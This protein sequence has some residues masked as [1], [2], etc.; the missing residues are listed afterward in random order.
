ADLSHPF[1]EVVTYT[2]EGPPAKQYPPG[3]IGVYSLKA[4][5]IAGTPLETIAQLYPEGPHPLRDDLAH[6]VAVSPTD[7][8]LT[9]GYPPEAS[10]VVRHVIFG[11]AR[12][13]ARPFLSRFQEANRDAFLELMRNVG[14]RILEVVR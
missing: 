9:I 4:P 5:S 11:T 13:Q 14:K 2:H 7:V 1:Q 10:P 8:Q 12:T 3:T 6:E